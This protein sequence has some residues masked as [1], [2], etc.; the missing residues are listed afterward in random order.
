M[1]GEVAP[2]PG[3]RPRGVSANIP[4]E[5]IDDMLREHPMDGNQV[6]PSYYQSEL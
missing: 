1:G 2:V 3:A 4:Q 5:A 6:N